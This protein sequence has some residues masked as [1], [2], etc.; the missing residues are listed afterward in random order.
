VKIEGASGQFTV[1]IR[2]RADNALYS[3]TLDPKMG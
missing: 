2:D 3:V 1:T